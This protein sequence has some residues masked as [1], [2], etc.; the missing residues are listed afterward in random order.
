MHH[1]LKTL[2]L[3]LFC[4]NGIHYFLYFI[5]SLNLFL[6]NLL[7]KNEDLTSEA[8]LSNSSKG[9]VRC[10]LVAQF[11]LLTCCLKVML[12]MT[13]LCMCMDFVNGGDSKSCAV[14][15]NVK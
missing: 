14:L 3:L 9:T 8:E 11:G 2:N 7:T 12:Q 4:L 10:S 1:V 5:L 15:C 13:F 6:S